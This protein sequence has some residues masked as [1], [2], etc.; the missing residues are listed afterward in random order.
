M[1]SLD[2]AIEAVK[3]GVPLFIV[4]NAHP[5]L[6]IRDDGSHYK[7][8]PRFNPDQAVSLDKTQLR[9]CRESELNL[10]NLNY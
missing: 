6:V 10:E 2:R 5:D 7:L 3:L 8:I 1:Q 4:R 9:Y